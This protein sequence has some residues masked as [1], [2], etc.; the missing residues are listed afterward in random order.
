MSS[1]D[2]WGKGIQAGGTAR[3]KA[4][5]QE[6]ACVFEEPLGRPGQ[7]EC[8]EQGEEGWDVKSEW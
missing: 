5:R 7:L 6:R 8:R 2:I 3:A 4:L 1:A